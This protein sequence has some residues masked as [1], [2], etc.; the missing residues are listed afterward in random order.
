VRAE[1][2]NPDVL[3]MQPANQAVRHDASD[4][5]NR[6]RDRRILAQGP[7]RSRS[8]VTASSHHS[9]SSAAFITN[10]AESDFRHAQA[11]GVARE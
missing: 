4:L 2:L 8:I 11:C 5:L 6:A 1:N 9:L 3:V 10:I 7:V